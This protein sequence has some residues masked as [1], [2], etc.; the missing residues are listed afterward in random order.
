MG[1]IPERRIFRQQSLSRALIPYLQITQAVRIGDLATFKEVLANYESVFTHDTTL[2]LIH[3]L[4]HNV[5]KT[6]LRKIN[7]SYSRISL[8]DICQKLHLESAEEAEYIVAKAIRDGVIDATIYHEEGYIQ[9]KANVDLYSTQEPHTAFHTRI[10]F[11]LNIHNDAVKAMRF[12]PDAHKKLL[13]GVHKER[14]REE[15]ELAEL[16]DEED[17][18]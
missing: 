18:M 6:G 15:R 13:D 11:C 2:S 12:P 5:I 7:L 16:V 4:R 9:S 14:L 17:D 1:E 3:R 10:T 8:A